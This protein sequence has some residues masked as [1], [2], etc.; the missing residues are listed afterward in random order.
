MIDVIRGGHKDT[1]ALHH[2]IESEIS[3]FKFTIDA[4]PGKVQLVNFVVNN[5]FNRQEMFKIQI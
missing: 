1:D 4:M 2:K 3:K 5:P